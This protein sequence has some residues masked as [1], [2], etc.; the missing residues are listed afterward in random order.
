M[1]WLLLLGMSK[2]VTSGLLTIGGHVPQFE[3]FTLYWIAGQL[4]ATGLQVKTIRL[5]QRSA[6]LMKILQGGGYGSVA[7]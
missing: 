5:N 7:K 4:R 1:H 2:Q 3:L 6:E